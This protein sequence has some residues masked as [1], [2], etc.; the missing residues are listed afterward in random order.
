M[1]LSTPLVGWGGIPF[2]I[3]H[4][5]DTLSPTVRPLSN[6]QTWYF[7]NEW[8]DFDTSWHKWSDM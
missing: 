5:V 4:P 1:T 6:F 3:S 8:T 2:P 7:E